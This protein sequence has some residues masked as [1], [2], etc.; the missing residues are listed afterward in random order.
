MGSF[1]VYCI[2]CGGPFI[3][4]P[5][6]KNRDLLKKYLKTNSNKYHDISPDGVW[7]DADGIIEYIKSNYNMTNS[8][9]SKLINSVAVLNEH[10]W[11]EDIIALTENTTDSVKYRDGTAFDV[12]NEKKRVF[13]P[14]NKNDPHIYCMHKKCYNLLKKNNYN[15]NFESIDDFFSKK[16]F[17]IPYNAFEINYGDITNYQGQM[18]YSPLAYLDKPY[19]LLNP[20]KNKKNASRILRLKYPFK[21]NKNTT[22]K[23]NVNRKGPSESA[24]LFAIGTKKKGNDGNMWIIIQDKNKI[25]KWKKILKG[26]NGDYLHKYTKYKLKYFNL[27]KNLI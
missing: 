11:L 16:E 19:I 10:K 14:V 4:Y 3:A 5:I 13:I 22:K 1:D 21:K 7:E 8:D 18:F 27:K 23:F 12:I 9:Y 2:I 20:M 15:I 6:I 26:G 17:D 24:T 25:K